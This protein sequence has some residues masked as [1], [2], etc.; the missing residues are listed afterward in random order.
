MDDEHKPQDEIQRE[1]KDTIK[2]T[3]D[4][5]NELSEEQLDK[6]AGG[7]K[8]PTTFTLLAKVLG[9]AANKAAQNR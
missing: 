7:A 1:V 4:V 9:Q 2:D 5:S 3:D 8:P 6:I